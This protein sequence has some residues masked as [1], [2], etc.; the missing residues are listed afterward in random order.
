MRHGTWCIWS[1]EE[2]VQQAFQYHFSDSFLI[3][4]GWTAYTGTILPVHGGYMSYR[5]A[6]T[7][8]ACWIIGI[9][10]GTQSIRPLTWALVLVLPLA[11]VLRKKPLLFTVVIALALGFTYGRVTRR[12]HWR[13]ILTGKQA[14]TG[15]VVGPPD[16]RARQ[17]Y[18]SVRTSLPAATLSSRAAPVTVLV[19]ADRYIPVQAGNTV[20]VSGPV[21]VPERFDGFNYPLFLE[22]DH[23]FGVV[24][25]AQVTVTDARV[26]QAPKNLL[27]N[28]RTKLERTVARFVPEPEAS[29]LSGL[30]LGSRRSIPSDVTDA[31]RATGTSHLVAISGANITFLVSMALGLLPFSHRG[32]QFGVVLFVAGGLAALT[33]GSA[34]V[35]RGA[36]VACTGSFIRMLGRR[37]WPLA[38]ILLAASLMLLKN[39]LLIR[40]D[41]GFQLS[42]M[43]YGG[44]LLFG[45]ACTRVAER[46]KLPG[47]LGGSLSETTA[48]SLGTAP[49]TILAQRFAARG[50]IVNPLVLWLIPIATALGFI[51]LALA[52]IPPLA[53]IMG[54]LCW[55]VLHL[56]LAIITRT[57][58]IAR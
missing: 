55:A 45:N 20:H 48:A 41:P 2:H 28:L 11:L 22:R 8:L 13:S 31:L 25:N 46:I 14:F 57:S 43:A 15:T 51:M 18:L 33:G 4:P 40:A 7:A 35:V 5:L 34:S 3:C 54:S 56:I 27:A 50:L 1:S 23:I 9:L 47:W 10:A 53:Q 58:S 32:I 17:Q 29:F 6:T 21:E 16:I 26:S 19:K 42:F 39:P 44:L 24:P 37:P 38:T 12:A 52:P 30:L 49:L 36:V